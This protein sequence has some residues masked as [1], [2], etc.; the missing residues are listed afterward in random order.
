VTRSWLVLAALLLLPLA[1]HA[2]SDATPTGFTPAPV[3]NQD[4]TAPTPGGRGA[5]AG[6]TLFGSLNQPRIA[7]RSGDGF[8]PGSSFTEGLQRRPRAAGGI[9]T[10]LAPSLSLK[11]P[12]Y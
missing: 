8:T 7:L 3:P 10:G 5:K 6:P 4:V 12:L 11:L 1:G 2:A 9:A